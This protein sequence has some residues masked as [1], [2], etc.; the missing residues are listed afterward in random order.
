MGAL[1]ES[2]IAQV[3]NSLSKERT[4]DYH[5][6]N[7][8]MLRKEGKN[9]EA[10]AEECNHYYNSNN[11]DFKDDTVWTD[12]YYETQWSTLLTQ[13]TFVKYIVNPQSRDAKPWLLMTLKTPYGEHAGHL[14]TFTVVLRNVICAAKSLDINL[15]FID[16]GADEFL[17]ETFTYW[18][19]GGYGLGVP[20]YVYVPH[21][22]YFYHLEQKLYG[23]G[24]LVQTIKNIGDEKVPQIGYGKA[25]TRWWYKEAVRGPRNAINIY[26][27]YAYN[28]LSDFGKF[29]LFQ[30]ARGDHKWAIGKSFLPYGSP[31]WGTIYIAQAECRGNTTCIAEW[32][33]EAEKQLL[34]FPIYDYIWKCCQH[35]NDKLNGWNVLT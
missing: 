17:K 20:Y 4:D 35:N 16:I 18:Y 3:K 12:K 15:G 8:A 25:G 34:K 14:Q 10:G 28:G 29:D 19:E 2:I 6:Y 7:V 21:D 30:W 32:D 5:R 27:E 9:E 33:A 11:M 22:G 31:D 24:D 26:L 1:R 13:E 23:S